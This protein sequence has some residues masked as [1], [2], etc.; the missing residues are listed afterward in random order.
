MIYEDLP[1]EEKK[2]RW[3]IVERTRLERR[4]E[5]KVVE[6]RRTLVKEKE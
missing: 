5:K 4:K 6:N 1:M 2:K 3:R